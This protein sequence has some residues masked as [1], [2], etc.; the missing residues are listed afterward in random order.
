MDL[1]MGKAWVVGAMALGP[2]GAPVGQAFPFNAN[3]STGSSTGLDAVSAS[4]AESCEDWTSATITT[5]GWIG[6]S[7]M[8]M[9][10]AGGALAWAQIGCTMPQQ[11]LCLE[12]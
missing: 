4:A 9:S 11:I 8:G 1:K 2:S 7:S 10:G 12:N 3:F 5:G 6:Q